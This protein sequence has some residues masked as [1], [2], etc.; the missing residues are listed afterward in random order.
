MSH[1]KKSPTNRCLLLS[2]KY[3]SGY[4]LTCMR[5]LE[6]FRSTSF[7]SPIVIL[8]DFNLPNVSL[9]LGSITLPELQTTDKYTDLQHFLLTND[10]CQLNCIKDYQNNILDLTLTNTETV[11]IL[12]HNSKVSK[13]DAYHQP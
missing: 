11:T 13:V 8:G 1:I 12:W 7:G 2:T 6:Y 5:C 9:L 4:L 10:L 3:R